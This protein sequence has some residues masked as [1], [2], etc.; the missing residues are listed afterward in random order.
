MPKAFSPPG[1]VP[2]CKKFLPTNVFL[3]FSEPI[4]EP[5]LKEKKKKKGHKTIRDECVGLHSEKEIIFNCPL[6]FGRTPVIEE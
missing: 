3:L 1:K 5:T 2:P 4:G 6:E